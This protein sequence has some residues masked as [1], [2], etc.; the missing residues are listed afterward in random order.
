MTSITVNPDAVPEVIEVTDTQIVDTSSVSEVIVVTPSGPDTLLES[1]TDTEVIVTV[2]TEILTDH[3]TE[4]TIIES[5]AQGPPGAQ[6]P[7][8]LSGGSVTTYVASVPISGHIAVVLDSTGLCLP[9]DAANPAH[10]AV[11]G[12]SIGAAIAGDPVTVITRG[13]LEHLGWTFTAD[14][15]V[16][17]GLAGALTQVLPGGAVFSKIIGVA[18]SATRVSLDFQSAIFH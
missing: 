14:Q 7:Q 15:P 18:V 9:A 5:A 13:V 6:G 8:G 3:W 11:A 16:Y 17:L 4:A 10:F 12:V 1:T 2:H